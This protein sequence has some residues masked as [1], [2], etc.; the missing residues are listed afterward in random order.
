[1]PIRNFKA[2]GNRKE[3]SQ[4]NVKK[5]NRPQELTTNMINLTIFP[6]SISSGLFNYF[7]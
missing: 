3:K 7:N 2:E 1:M 6:F 5:L 4:L